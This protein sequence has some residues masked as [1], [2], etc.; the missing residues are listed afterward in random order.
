MSDQEFARTTEPKTAS[1]WRKLLAWFLIYV[2]LAVLL[3]LAWWFYETAEQDQKTET[4]EESIELL[5][6]DIEIEEKSAVTTPTQNDSLPTIDRQEDT[7]HTERPAVSLDEPESDGDTHDVE[8]RDT[9]LSMGEPDD[10]LPLE[11]PADSLDV[12]ESKSDTS[13]VGTLDKPIPTAEPNDALRLE[14]TDV[15]LD[16]T[17]SESDTGDVERQDTTIPM[18]E[19]KVDYLSIE[20][21]LMLA[22]MYL[23]QG[24]EISL[25]NGHL[26]DAEDEIATKSGPNWDGLLDDVRS[27]LHALTESSDVDTEE[28]YLEIEALRKR[29]D[30]LIQNAR[31]TDDDEQEVD[32]AQVPE[33]SESESVWQKLQSQVESVVTVRKLDDAVASTENNRQAEGALLDISL[34]LKQA[35]LALMDSNKVLYDSALNEL[36]EALPSLPLVDDQSRS[37]IREELH[38]LKDRFLLNARP[39]TLSSYDQLMRLIR[40]QH[41]E[42]VES[43]QRG[44]P[45]N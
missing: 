41:S 21:P 19:P 24:A 35:Q 3:F 32:A 6:T 33:N 17:E 4:Y 28:I 20:R 36:E 25:I 44:D 7:I 29:F 30:I 37:E 22:Q 27:D 12:T 45:R 38:R 14:S 1:L 34:R 8:S 10:A 40:E 5:E 15:S 43:T 39:A 31:K 18:V 23:M 42:N 26:R 11:T 13:D 16:V 9:L 2:L